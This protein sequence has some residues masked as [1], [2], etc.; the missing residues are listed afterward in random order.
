MLKPAGHG[1]SYNGS[2]IEIGSSPGGYKNANVKE[3]KKGVTHTI[4]N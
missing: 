1:S 2:I 3:N 4:L